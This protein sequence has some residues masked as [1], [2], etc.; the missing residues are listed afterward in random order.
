MLGLSK[1]KRKTLY[2]L[3]NKSKIWKKIL[4]DS[5]FI[6]CSYRGDLNETCRRIEKFTG[7]LKKLRDYT[8][9]EDFFDGISPDLR[10]GEDTYGYNDL[11]SIESTLEYI[12]DRTSGVTFRLNWL[13]GLPEKVYTLNKNEKKFP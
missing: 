12:S 4:N 2:R 9:L 13:I 6:D 7:V 11:D 3:K 10:F 8:I 5:I 1:M